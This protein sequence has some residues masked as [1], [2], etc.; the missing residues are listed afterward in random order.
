[1]RFSPSRAATSA[2]DTSPCD[3]R[4][5]RSALF[6]RPAFGAAAGQMREAAAGAALTE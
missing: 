4:I 6:R 1:M 3:S 2:I 5:S